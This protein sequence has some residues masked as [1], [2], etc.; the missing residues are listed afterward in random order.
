MEPKDT[1]KQSMIAILNKKLPWPVFDADLETVDT[2]AIDN[3]N[4]S[5]VT[6]NDTYDDNMETLDSGMTA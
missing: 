3:L 5:K 2:T 1:L 4:N 6:S